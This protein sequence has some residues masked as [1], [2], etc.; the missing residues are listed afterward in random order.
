[1]QN[2]ASTE[3]VVTTPASAAPEQDGVA[4]AGTSGPA[5]TTSHQNPDIRPNM[6]LKAL[7]LATWG[8]ATVFLPEGDRFNPD[9]TLACYP[10]RKLAWGDMAVAHRTLPCKSKVLV[11]LPRTGRCVVARVMDRGPRRA[12][13]DLA[14]A[15]ARAIHHNMK[16]N[17]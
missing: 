8:V 12:M 14:P 2:A 11:C 9:P 13:V 4:N 7:L 17:V 15:V 10:R 5:Q 1:M 3:T 16:E 6:I